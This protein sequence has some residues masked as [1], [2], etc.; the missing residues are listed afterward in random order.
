[1]GGVQRGWHE[2]LWGY[3]RLRV[4]R[5]DE[6]AHPCREVSARLAAALG[7]MSLDVREE[8]RVETVPVREERIER[9]GTGECMWGRMKYEF[10]GEEGCLVSS[11]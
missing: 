10:K 11:G 6:V 8:R 4:F 1:M 5:A 3:E 7:D 2:A 9:R